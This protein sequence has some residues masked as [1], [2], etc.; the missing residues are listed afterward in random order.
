MPDAS[1]P[2]DTGVNETDTANPVTPPV[3]TDTPDSSTTEPVKL[4]KNA[5]KKAARENALPR[6]RFS[7]G[8]NAKAPG[9]KPGTA[10]S[11]SS[12][13]IDKCL[14]LATMYEETINRLVDKFLSVQGAQHVKSVGSGAVAIVAMDHRAFGEVFFYVY[15]GKE[16]SGSIGKALAFHSIV[17][18]D[19]AIGKLEAFIERHRGGVSFVGIVAL[20]GYIQLIVQQNA[21]IIEKMERD[22]R[23]AQAREEK[24][25]APIDVEVVSE[26]SDV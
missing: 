17:L 21:A 7:I 2:D 11:S 24:S 10:K 1:T 25:K 6:D 23:E 18:S 5:R 8:D 19:G 13:N 12:I 3:S 9:G 16:L 26:P 22:S 20:V 15:K 4:S 14:E